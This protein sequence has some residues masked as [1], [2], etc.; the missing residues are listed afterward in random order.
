MLLFSVI[1]ATFSLGLT[2]AS[3]SIPLFSACSCEHGRPSQ[4][5]LPAVPE[6]VRLP[7][8]HDRAPSSPPRWT[9]SVGTTRCHRL[10][11][12]QADGRSAFQVSC[13]MLRNVAQP[14]FFLRF[15]LNC[16][17]R[18][19]I[20]TTVNLSTKSLGQTISHFVNWYRFKQTTHSLV[21]WPHCFY[22]DLFPYLIILRTHSL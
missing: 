13:G 2:K 19:D 9:P 22:Q 8:G 10:R 20:S 16:F 21:F 17:W 15:G 1:E 6:R 11:K 4:V 7:Q 3:F 12:G 5:L 18:Y 14:F